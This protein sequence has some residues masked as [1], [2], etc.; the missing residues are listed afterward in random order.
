MLSNNH[1]YFRSFIMS[2]KPPFEK[3]ENLTDQ[4]F[5]TAT[6]KEGESTSMPARAIRKLGDFLGVQ[7]QP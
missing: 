6:K 2:Q 7:R 5:A 4:L 3:V 1:N